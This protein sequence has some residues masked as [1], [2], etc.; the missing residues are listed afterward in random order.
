MISNVISLIALLGASDDGNTLSCLEWISVTERGQEYA[1]VYTP[2]VL[3]AEAGDSQVEYFVGV[4]L[5]FSG[6]E[7]EALNLLTRSSQGSYAPSHF[8]LSEIYKKRGN[9]EKSE[10]HLRQCLSIGLPAQC[11]G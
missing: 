1:H 7:D 3:E 4:S 5:L 8:A 6:N 2:C 11:G 9:L 10:Y